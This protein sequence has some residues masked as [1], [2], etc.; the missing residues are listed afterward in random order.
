[1]I[2]ID[3]IPDLPNEEWRVIEGYGGKYPISNMGRTKSLKQSEARLL[4]P[5]V[6]NKGYERV[7]LCRK[8]KGRHFLVSRLVA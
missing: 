1:M 5:F 8:G 2:V 4:T 6:N 3:T 7:C